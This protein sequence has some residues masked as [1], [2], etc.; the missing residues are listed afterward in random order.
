LGW[1]D[2]IGGGQTTPVQWF[3]EIPWWANLSFHDA[4]PL[5]SFFQ[6]IF[7]SVLGD[8]AFVSRLPFALAG[9][10]TVILIYF[11]L[12]DYFKNEYLAFLGAGLAT[13]SSY[14]TWAGR[15]GYLEGVQIFFIT[16]SLFLFLRYILR[17]D[18]RYLYAWGISMG[19]ALMSKYTALF[20]LPVVFFYFLI[21]DR[22]IFF[23]K[24]IWLAGVG[25]LI[26]LI[27]VIIYNFNVFITRGHFDAALSSMIG[28]RHE[29]FLGIAGRSSGLGFDRFLE[30]LKVL[31]QN[32]S[33]P[34][35][36]LLVIGFML[37]FYR[38]YTKKDQ[39]IFAILIH[40]VLAILLLILVGPEVRF[41]SIIMPFLVIFSILAI[42]E[43]IEQYS[44]KKTYL[45]VI[46]STLGLIFIGEFLFNVNTNLLARPVGGSLFYSKARFYNRGFNQ[47]DDYITSE[48]GENKLEVA[49]P[50]NLQD[51][52]RISF[53]ENNFWIFDERINWF[54]YSWY[55]QRYTFYYN[56][57]L[58]S[59][60]NYL[61][62]LSEEQKK[63]IF[64]YFKQNKF[65]GA[66][67]IYAVSDSVLDRKKK[68]SKEL[69]DL[70]GEV[71]DIFENNNAEV[72][73]IKNNQGDVAFKVY[74]LKF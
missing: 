47:L 18:N 49:R 8:S 74:Y 58:I 52:S 46:F 32:S 35:V 63:D 37:A 1:L 17:K 12:K 38:C 56:V 7:F 31:S 72:F 11:I 33:Y 39:W 29:D 70:M 45:A 61:S 2:F 55:L 65:K 68:E 23:K 50:K 13:I 73:E 15:V 19:L 62:I 40:L 25:T 14:L 27:P 44:S 60:Y 3:G 22:K 28:M 69:T 26:V 16:L 4:P 10:G 71:S 43:L 34:I 30:F 5:V 24:D 41:L 67:Y 21:W 20:I 59:A 36:F 64:S 51:S 42:N 9:V 54:A 57:P 53:V 48:I 6:Y 66:Y